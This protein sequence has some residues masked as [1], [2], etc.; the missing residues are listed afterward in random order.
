MKKMFSILILILITVSLSACTFSNNEG[1]EN[2]VSY[3]I[4]IENLENGSVS[5][6]NP[7]DS[8]QENEYIEFIIIPD[9]GYRLV[10]N[11]LVYNETEIIEEYYF[12]INMPAMDINI[13]AEFE[14]IPVDEIVI[15]YSLLT[16]RLNANFWGTT[17]YFNSAS[18]NMSDFEVDNN[19]EISGV[20]NLS[21]ENF[22]IG[23]NE[24]KDL[25]SVSFLSLVNDTA[26]VNFNASFN[27]TI[28]YTYNGLGYSNGTYSNDENYSFEI[29]TE[30]V[31]NTILVA[32]EDNL[33]GLTTLY[34]SINVQYL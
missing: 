24:K 1:E 27:C 11:S 30:D 9:E 19:Y 29:T 28:F 22:N 6:K 4:T 25:D 17:Y 34:L 14:L 7:K 32:L 21:V 20:S 8:Y 3:N 23:E 15:Y 5:V 31:E 33:D 26:T 18:F 12:S 16:R 10:K 2:V 13:F